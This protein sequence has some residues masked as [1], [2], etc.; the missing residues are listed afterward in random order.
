MEKNEILQTSVEVLSRLESE[1]GSLYDR[2]VVLSSDISRL[3]E[4]LSE[5]DRTLDTNRLDTERLTM[6]SKA[7]QTIIDGTSSSNLKRVVEIVN[8]ALDSVFPNQGIVFDITS[9]VKRGVPVYELKLSQGGV[10]G[11][12][13]SFGGGVLSVV[14]VVLKIMLNVM[15]RRSPIVCLDE[16]LSGL[17]EEYIEPMSALLRDICNRFRIYL[18]L[19]THQK[20]FLLCCDYAFRVKS[21]GQRSVVE[22][23]SKSQTS[24]DE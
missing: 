23:I 4:R 24:V 13:N 5:C 14:S 17:S 2:K 8:M 16:T 9:S 19:V 18:I 21:M 22:E 1:R 11:S 6:A 15:S 7:L 3:K 12:L 10:E 20:K